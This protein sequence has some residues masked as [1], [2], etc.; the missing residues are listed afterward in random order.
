MKQFELDNNDELPKLSRKIYIVTYI[1]SSLLS[2]GIVFCHVVKLSI[3]KS[4]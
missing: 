4:G 1:R 2:L 3:T